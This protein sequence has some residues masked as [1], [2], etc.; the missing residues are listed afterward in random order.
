MDSQLWIL[1]SLPLEQN[2]PPARV[3]STALLLLLLSVAFL[4][5]Y[6]FVWQLCRWAMTLCPCLF[7]HPIK[8]ACT[9]THTLAH[10]ILALMLP[11]PSDECGLCVSLPWWRDYV[12]QFPLR[13]DVFM[14]CLNRVHSFPLRLKYNKSWDHTD[15][16]T[17]PHM[18]AK[19]R[20]QATSATD[21]DATANGSQCAVTVSVSKKKRESVCVPRG[22]LCYS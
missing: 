9:H 6:L 19:Q 16:H 18:H 20:L 3:N 5:V 21:T 4:S 15:A 12:H 17:H 10:S 1:S 22:T 13:L 7:Y 8:R 11:L 2:V 14:L